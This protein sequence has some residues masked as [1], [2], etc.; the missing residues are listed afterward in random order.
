MG[1][2]GSLVRVQSARQLEGQALQ[3]KLRGFVFSIALMVA[4]IRRWH[5][6]TNGEA[7]PILRRTFQLDLRLPC[8]ETCDLRSLQPSCRPSF[9]LPAQKKVQMKKQ[10][11]YL[12]I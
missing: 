3:R 4:V 9:F 1:C 2:K 8:K 5:I 11:C 10:R 6:A 7:S 12:I